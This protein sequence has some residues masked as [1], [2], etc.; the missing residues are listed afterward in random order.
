MQD[1]ENFCPQNRAAWRE[2]LQNFHHQKKSVCLIYFKKHS[3]QFNIAYS[4]A[5]DEALCFGWIDSKVNTIDAV[6]YKQIFTPRS[7]KSVWSKVNKQKIEN[8]T[9]QGLMHESGLA[10]VA[11]AQANGSWTILDEAEALI[12]P[13]DVEKAF[14]EAPTLKPIFEAWAPS[15]RKMFL[16]QLLFVK[17]PANRAK[18]ISA[19]FVLLEAEKCGDRNQKG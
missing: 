4:D 10:A 17:T 18:K 14:A 1:I 15:K 13:A 9:N 6:S 16:Q 7:P 2:W 3:P 19:L 8:L 11:V 5:V 12:L